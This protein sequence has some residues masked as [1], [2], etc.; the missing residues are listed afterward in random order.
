MGDASDNP[1]EGAESVRRDLTLMPGWA[2]ACKIVV[3]DGKPLTG[4]RACGLH[5]FGR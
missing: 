4:V 1:P 2:F 5:S 3:P